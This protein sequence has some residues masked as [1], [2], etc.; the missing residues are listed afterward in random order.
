MSTLCQIMLK[1]VIHLL[2]SFE[3]H[4]GVQSNR[5]ITGLSYTN[6]PSLSFDINNCNFY[7]MRQGAISFDTNENIN[8]S[9]EECVFYKCRNGRYGGAICYY[10][11]N[12]QIAIKKICGH[13]CYIYRGGGYCDYQFA[14]ISLSNDKI[15]HFMDSSIHG[16]PP[17][18]SESRS[19]GCFIQGGK[20]KIVSTNISKAN[21]YD[22][23]ALYSDY[24]RGFTFSYNTIANSVSKRNH[25]IF[26]HNRY[27]NDPYN[28]TY[29]NIV[30]NID[31]ATGGIIITIGVYA[32]RDCI[33]MQNFVNL[34][35]I[36]SITTIQRCYIQ[37][38]GTVYTKSNPTVLDVKLSD[39]LTSTY[40]LM[41]FATQVCSI[42]Y[43]INTPHRSY[44][45]EPTS[46]E[47]FSHQ[48]GAT[49]LI[50]S[51]FHV[52]LTTQLNIIAY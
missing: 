21:G 38:F 24:S 30:N 13:S 37:H 29:C 22:F 34:F 39:G 50:E 36:N 43:T 41:H 31:A 15:N 27:S 17:D 8:T 3:E 23:S 51:I 49:L 33:L 1:L 2:S 9:I 20:Q 32:F 16:C 44:P 42:E 6:P 25:I 48:D 28:I 4:F 26:F 40:T 10:V 52:L 45:P 11:E 12:A 47:L 7:D 46:C 5:T 35:V 19:Y 18:H 14:Y